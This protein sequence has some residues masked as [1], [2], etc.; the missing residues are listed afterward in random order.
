MQHV[1]PS[2]LNGT[3]LQMNLDNG[4]SNKREVRSLD[5]LS[6]VVLDRNDICLNQQACGLD[7]VR[8]SLGLAYYTLRESTRQTKQLAGRFV[9]GHACILSKDQDGCNK[10]R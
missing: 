8:I 10:S 7:L 2:C 5:L 9:R 1:K 4:L 6:F 3:L